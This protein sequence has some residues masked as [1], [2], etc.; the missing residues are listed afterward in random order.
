MTSQGDLD[1]ILHF[2]DRQHKKAFDE[3]LAEGKAAGYPEGVA[4]VSVALLTLM[5]IRVR[6]RALNVGK[7]WDFTVVSSMPYS[8]FIPARSLRGPVTQYMS[9]FQEYGAAI[10]TQGIAQQPF[11]IQSKQ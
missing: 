1:A 3:G 9:C 7:N 5:C 8:P 2:E 11:S 4:T 6:W 10:S